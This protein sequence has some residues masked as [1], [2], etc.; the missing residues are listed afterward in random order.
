MHCS[1]TPSRNS[2]YGNVKPVEGGRGGVHLRKRDYTQ[3]ELQFGLANTICIFGEGGGN[4]IQIL[5]EVERIIEEAQ[6][7]LFPKWRT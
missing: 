2:L 1:K 7:C 5:S 3:Q 6:N 4:L